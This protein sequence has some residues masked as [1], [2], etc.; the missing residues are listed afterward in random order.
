MTTRFTFFF[1][2]TGVLLSTA[3]LTA[4]PNNVRIV[5]LSKVEAAKG[6]MREKL[7][8]DWMTEPQLQEAVAK[9]K[10]GRQQV[11]FFE[12]N[13]PRDKWRAILTDK[14]VFRD[15]SWWA[16]FGE[17]AIEAKLNEEMKQGR[18]PAF[19]ARNGNY[20][21]MLTVGPDDYPTAR[22]ELAELGIGEPKVK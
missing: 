21:S 20:F 6:R 9:G 19:I 4:A 2:A 12:Y 13:G 10:A 15:F 5:T 14:V 7:F 8:T 11:L 17:P 1:F 16:L 18:K 3:S 22:K